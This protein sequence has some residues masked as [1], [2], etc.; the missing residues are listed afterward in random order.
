L[1]PRST[2][3]NTEN[4]AIFESP[5]FAQKLRNMIIDDTKLSWRV[6]ETNGKI[7]WCGRRY[8]EEAPRKYHHCPDTTIFKRIFKFFTK[9]IPEKFV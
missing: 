2:Y 8:G 6:T 5:E 4:V 7:T 9:I 1:D 3:Y